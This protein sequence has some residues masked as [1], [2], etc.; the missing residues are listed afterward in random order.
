MDGSSASGRLWVDGLTDDG[1]CVVRSFVVGLMRS[2]QPFRPSH[3]RMRRSTVAGRW[4]AQGARRN[5][6]V[7]LLLLLLLQTLSLSSKFWRENAV[8]RQREEEVSIFS[9][10]NECTRF[11][12][13]NQALRRESKSNAM[14][15]KR[16]CKRECI[17]CAAQARNA[18][19]RVSSESV[20]N[21]GSV[22]QWG[23]L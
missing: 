5:P 9:L 1:R 10:R 17:S 8:C 18:L 15:G 2:L 19:T 16:T 12:T 7:L 14:D 22:R 13:A 20:Y 4:S 11:V 21:R 3:A 23:N 6:R